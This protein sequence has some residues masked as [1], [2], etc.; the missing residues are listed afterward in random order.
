ME[1]IHWEKNM[2]QQ[3]SKARTKEKTLESME[4]YR[5]TQVTLSTYFKETTLTVL[6][7]WKMLI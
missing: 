6:L 2:E 4:K 3:V 7:G 1:R 5:A